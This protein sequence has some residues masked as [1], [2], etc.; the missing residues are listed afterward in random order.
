MI[1]EF[2]IQ[3]IATAGGVAAVALAIIKF[4]GSKFVEMLFEKYKTL[5]EKDLEKYKSE[6]VKKQHVT[7]TLFDKKIEVFVCL[8]EDFSTMIRMLADVIPADGNT[9]YPSEP[10]EWKKY[11]S[12][13]CDALANS[14]LKTQNDLMNSTL[15]IKEDHEKVYRELLEL[16]AHQIKQLNNVRERSRHDILN[17]EDFNKTAQ[18]NEKYHTL[19]SSIREYLDSLEI[20]K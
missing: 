5:Q 10:E 15:F 2:L 14:A 19:N 9:K 6:L 3:L 8:T 12:E 17:I 11:V 13:Y 4:G 1:Q 16:I 20:L 7:K 18:I